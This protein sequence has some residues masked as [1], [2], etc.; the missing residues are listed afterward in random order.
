MVGRLGEVLTPHF[1]HVSATPTCT[2]ES[3]MHRTAKLLVQTGFNA[4]RTAGRAYELRWRCRSCGIEQHVDTVSLCTEVKSET[5]LAR[6]T[7][8]D[9]VFV[10]RRPFVVEIVVAHPLEPST[11]AAYAEANLPVF[12]IEPTPDRLGELLDEIRASDTLNVRNARCTK[13]RERK[14]IAARVRGVIGELRSRPPTAQELVLWSYDRHENEL[15]DYL[16]RRLARIGKRLLRAGFRQA[17]KKQWLFF[18]ELPD[19]FGMFFADLGGTNDVPIWTDQRPLAYV[20]TKRCS[21]EERVPL[22]RALLQHG[23]EIGV[24][25]RLSFFEQAGSTTVE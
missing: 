6:G 25:M 24:P 23:S 12:M 18:V 19:N 1:A 3:W 7:R 9:L 16:Q 2:G 22:L 4:A 20:K 8:S 21:E 13:C 10:G 15:R 5:E 11:K 17:A 14:A